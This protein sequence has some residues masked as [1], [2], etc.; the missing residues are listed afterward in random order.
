MERTILALSICIG[1]ISGIL[2]IPTVSATSTATV[3]I[4]IHR[5]QKIDSIEGS[6]DQ[7]DW[8]YYVG[9][10]EDGGNNYQWISP[11]SIPMI[12]NKDDWTV[13]TIHTF[14]SIKKS[15][16]KI[17]IV[18]CEE[19]GWP[20]SDDLADISS[21][22]CSGCNYDDVADPILPDNVDYGKYIGTY[23]LATNTLTG[24]TTI[25][26]LNYYKTSGEYDN[27]PGDEN[28]A[29]V[30]FNISD[31]YDAPVA[32]AG[33]EHTILTGEKVNFD[34]GQS[35]AST[36][37]SI[38]DYKWDVDG[39]NQ[40]DYQ[41]Q[42]ASYTYS[43]KGTYTVTLE[44]TDSI[45]VKDTD[46]STVTVQN[47]NPTAAFEYN[48][49]N[50]PHPTTLDTVS[51]TDTSTDSDGTLASWYWN[52]GDGATS[53]ER[54]PT[55][56]YTTGGTYTVSLKAT[57]NDGGYDTET[58][59]IT[60]V[61]MANIVGTVKDGEGN[62]I[63]GATVRLYTAGTTSLLKSA[64]TDSMGRYT[65]TEVVTNTYDIEASKSGYDNNKKSS[66]YVSS[67]ENTIDFVLTIPSQPSPTKPDDGNGTPGFELI[68][69]ICAIALILIGN[70]TRKK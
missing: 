60:V 62:L 4:T 13:D 41:T 2:I 24:D 40:W 35:A 33:T 30:Y 18:L 59:S 26:E 67:G 8:Y 15:V 7:A 11:S 57:D 55:H 34:G 3:S 46:T 9:I 21:D 31:N 56:K 64:T 63:S 39:D 45:G 52:F 58:K 22:I 29:A 68:L 12:D 32:E 16:V 50:S 61:E 70:R 25:R 51:F 10:S 14:S 28:D 44:V 49:K 6:G 23:N 36:G 43:K 1:L 48:P 17:S 20:F 66:K 5:I 54:N 38:T 27:I 65:I 37:S 42:I 53:T 47:R 69:V 19:D